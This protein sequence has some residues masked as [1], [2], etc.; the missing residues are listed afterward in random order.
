MVA[1]EPRTWCVLSMVSIT[2]D[3]SQ[4]PTECFYIRY[5]SV[6]GC[7]IY[8][9]AGAGACVQRPE[10]PVRCLPWLLSTLFFETE[11]LKEAGTQ[12]IR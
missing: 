1:L 6:Y 8:I 10:V 2:H 9:C 12:G 7:R 11:F 3:V 5:L 4:H